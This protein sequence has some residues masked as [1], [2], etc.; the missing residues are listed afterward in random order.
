MTINSVMA[1]G[2]SPSALLSWDRNP[3]NVIGWCVRVV[4]KRERSGNRNIL[5]D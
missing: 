2:W 5:T 3:E 1:K 4:K